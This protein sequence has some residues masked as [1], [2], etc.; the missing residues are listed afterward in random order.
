MNHQAP[1][2]TRL[3]PTIQTFLKVLVGLT[4]LSILYS[5]VTF[6]AGLT[7][8]YVTQLSPRSD[9]FGDYTIYVDKFH[10]FH[11]PQFFTSGFPFTYPAPVSLVYYLFYNG[12][13]HHG[14]A[15]FITFCILAYCAA[16]FGFYTALV[17]RGISA[18]TASLVAFCLVVTSWPA[19][20]VVDRANMEITVFV[21]VALSLWA[22][23]TGRGY[24]AAILFG[25][26]A[27]LKLFPFVFCA[28]FFSKRQY[29]HLA[30]TLASFF[31][32]SIA[33]LALL[34][35]SIRS[36]YQGIAAGLAFFKKAYMQRWNPTENGVDHS[37]FAFIKATLIVVFHVSPR[38]DFVHALSAYLAF[39]AL[40]GLSLY[41][42]TIRFLPLVNQV[43]LLTI[44]SIYFTPFS[45]DG[46]LLHLYAPFAMLVFVSLNAQRTG[47]SVRALK[48]AM[49][50]FAILFAAEDFLL[51]PH[52]AQ[53]F[54]GEFKCLVLGILFF[55]ALRYPFGPPAAQD[56]IDQGLSFAPPLPS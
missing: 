22:Y 41:F 11:T 37:M 56:P 20:L 29:K 53:H 38:H 23:A 21:V 35:P 39:T 43:L 47:V 52:H 7:R 28:L 5:V 44:A 33:S 54:E 31:A 12:F 15:A 42:I 19:I 6:F 51:T 2:A 24:L 50:C 16:A 34:G 36:A 1:I 40:L 18:A 10:L 4:A 17:R 45:G 30:L 3:P 49:V 27:S 48:P 46:T 8:P 55:L 13:G 26:A 25:L 32:F 9:R 14:E